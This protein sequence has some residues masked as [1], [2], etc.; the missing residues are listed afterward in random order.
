MFE[1]PTAVAPA[2]AIRAAPKGRTVALTA[3]ITYL[4]ILLRARIQKAQRLEGGAS[5]IEW[6]VITAI[7]VTICSAVGVILYNTIKGA[8]ESIDTETGVGGGG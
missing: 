5:A 8:A 1:L 7:L 4:R 3:F 6:V 2:T